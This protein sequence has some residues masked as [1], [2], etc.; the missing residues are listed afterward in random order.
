MS[1]LAAQMQSTARPVSRRRVL[2]RIA[3]A[4]A[5]ASLAVPALAQGRVIR[6]G[7]TFDN[8]GVEKA[9]G[10][11][12]FQ[13]SSAYFNALNQAGGIHGAKVELV[14]SD[15]QF[16][17]DLARSNALAFSADPTVLALLHPLGTRQTAELMDAVPGMAVVGPNTG[18]ISLRKKTAP[19]TFWVRAN[20]DQEVDKLIATASVL[21]ITR[22]GIVHPN[23]PLGLSV[24]AAFRQALAKVRLEPAVIA[25]TPGTTSMEVEPAA[26]AI[27][28]AS[29][30][31]VIMSLAGTAPAFVRALRKAGGNST[32]YGLSIAASASGI[33]DLGELAR[34]LGFSIIV[35]SPFSTRYEIVRRYQADMAASGSRDFS[36][37]SLE[38]YID[39][40]VLAEGLR[41]A[42]PSPTR[43]GLI[44]ALEHV[45]GLDLGG[46]KISFGRGNRE[47]SQ[48][49]DV[50]VIG[51]SGRMIS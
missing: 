5:A 50:A 48:F 23:D 37:P 6:I 44:A 46:V 42:G 4:V 14:M 35:P 38:G 11:G 17:P 49:V 33:R 26:E 9:N 31:V 2:T 1:E 47:G 15:D 41:R 36:L 13:G 32:V 22:I 29:P 45:E 7:T 43:A 16:K 27:A 8:S 24:L 30:Q 25:T 21:G 34:G 51:T 40:C 12:L 20:Y 10:S 18:T 19:N 3:G 28:K 39:A